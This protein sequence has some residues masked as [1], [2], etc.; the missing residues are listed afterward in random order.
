MT[1]VL[2]DLLLLDVYCRIS[3]DYDGTTRSVDE[4][5]MECLDRID[6]EPRWAVG[7]VFKDH[8]K[9]AWSPKVV[10]PEFEEMMTRL[11]SGQS[12]G[13]LVWNLSRFTRKPAEGERLLALAERGIVVA[14]LDG[15]YNITTADG[16]KAFRDKMTANAHESDTTSERSS[17]GKRLKA[18]RG[19]SN[20]TNRGFGRPGYLPKPEGWETGDPREYVSDA[21]LRRERE[22]VVD[23]TDRILAGEHMAG[24]CQEWN[25]AGLLTTTGK[26]WDSQRLRQMLEAPAIGGLVEYKGTIMADNGDGPLDRET[27]ERLCRYFASRKRGRPATAYLLSGLLTC[28][29]CGSRLYG[30][31]VVS[32]NPYPDGEVRRQ[33]WCQYRM[34]EG[35]HGAGCG[36][37]TIDQRFADAVVA[38][39]VVKRLGDP[40]HA[41]RVA[42]VAA[43][44]QEEH[45]RLRAELDRLNSEIDDLMDKVGTFGWTPDRVDRAVAKYQPQVEEVQQ[46][47]ARLEQIPTDSQR[48]AAEDAQADW[49]A[50]NNTERRTLI[51]RAF[52]EGLVVLKAESSGKASLVETRIVPRELAALAG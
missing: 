25:E 22:A 31:P 48:G 45:R 39:Y 34:A 29:L 20:A 44:V 4:Q 32:Q 8:A 16:R 52:P 10:R 23:A 19:R 7:K 13:L 40:R 50:A 3:V 18:R 46:K 21:Q 43:R 26:R 37:L 2:L 35:E 1:A 17:R 6:Q 15:E 36:R 24:I 30:R 5:E 33:Y 12:H 49:D 28:D 14:S 51:R 27:W 9:S 38:R 41:D 47:I 42:R 11:E